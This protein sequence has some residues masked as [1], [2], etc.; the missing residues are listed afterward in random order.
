[1]G[2]YSPA[3]VAENY[4]NIGTSKAHLS[5]SKMILLGIL[6]GAFIGFGGVGATTAAVSI[7]QASVGKLVGACVFPA[8]LAMVLLAGAEL[9]TG[10]CLMTIPLLKKR[11]TMGQMLRNWIWV[12]IGNLTAGGMFLGNLLPVTL[13]NIVGGAICVGM[14]YYYCYL[15]D[16]ES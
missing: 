6:A 2:L 10:N 16:T 12:W 1:M 9:F 15:R 7:S 8:G 4:I 14:V 5:I 13:G 3:E 11:I